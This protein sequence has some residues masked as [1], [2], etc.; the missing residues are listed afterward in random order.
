MV[1]NFVLSAAPRY[2]TA[3]DGRLVLK[4]D[5]DALKQESHPQVQF[6]L[7]PWPVL[8]I[9]QLHCIEILFEFILVR[10]SHVMVYNAY[11]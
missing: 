5:K 11:S 7:V 6:S 3:I 8:F 1:S 10:P 9:K 4:A 2:D